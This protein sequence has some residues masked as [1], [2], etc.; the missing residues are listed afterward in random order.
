MDEE[1]ETAKLTIKMILPDRPYQILK[2]GALIAIPALGTAYN[3]LSLVW[4]LPYG[5][6]VLQT[7]A[8]VGALIGALIG[9]SSRN[10]YKTQDK[11]DDL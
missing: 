6:A 1:K 3:A 8:I 4:Q 5:S 11:G 9:I 10:F 2:W 7:C